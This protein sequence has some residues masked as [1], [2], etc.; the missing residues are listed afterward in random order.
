VACRVVVLAARR[1]WWRPPIQVAY[2]DRRN[3]R[4]LTSLLRSQRKKP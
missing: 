4:A 1:A 3:R 2:T